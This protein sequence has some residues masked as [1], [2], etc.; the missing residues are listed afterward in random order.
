MKRMVIAL[1]IVIC[2]ASLYGQRNSL[3]DFFDNYADR[4]GYTSVIINGNIF[5]FLRNLDSDDEDINMLDRKVTSIRIVS[6]KGDHFARTTDFASELRPLIRRG[7]Y[8]ELM[9]VKDHDSDLSVM[10]RGS[11]NTIRELLVIASGENQAVIQI[12]GNFTREDIDR[13]SE[14]DGERLAYLEM[15]ETSG[16]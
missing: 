15:L 16:K 9:S 5:G 13:L 2:T 6:T 12:M 11:G 8:E 14:N 1:F 4:E 3:D 10:V 7:R